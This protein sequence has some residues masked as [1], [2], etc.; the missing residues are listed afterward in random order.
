MQLKHKVDNESPSGALQSTTA[1]QLL[2]TKERK[3]KKSINGRTI[4]LGLRDLVRNDKQWMEKSTP[5]LFGSW[6]MKRDDT[7]IKAPFHLTPE[8]VSFGEE[9]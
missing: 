9:H 2:P 6:E 7:H 4:Q 1:M 5:P 3:Q 8:V